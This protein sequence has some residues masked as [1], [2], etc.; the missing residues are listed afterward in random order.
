MELLKILQWNMS[1][2]RDDIDTIYY[3]SLGTLQLR[4]FEDSCESHNLVSI[5]WNN[6]KLNIRYTYHKALHSCCLCTNS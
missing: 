6:I 4:F 5:A 3:T 1:T 2:T